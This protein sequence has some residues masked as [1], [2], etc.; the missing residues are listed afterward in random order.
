VPAIR[1]T[2]AFAVLAAARRVFLKRGYHGA[3]V[4]QIAE[5]AGFSTGVVYSQFRGKA[6]LFLTLLESRI[7]ER[8][9]ANLRA[10]ERHPG[11]RGIERLIEQAAGVDRAEPEWGLLVIEFRV[12]SARDPALGRRYAA[13]HARTVAGME[14]AI[15]LVYD[16]S[17]R[18]GSLPA[19]QLARLIVA[20]GAGTR[21]ERAVEPDTGLPELFGRLLAGVMEFRAS[22][23]DRGSTV[24]EGQA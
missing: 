5:E 22:E 16:R 8:A 19:A 7:E 12:Q 1:S 17:E 14:H 4:E 21:L 24:K 13:L 10:V 18:P 6:D 3:S 23:P 11:D 9:A 20:V 15:K 2:L